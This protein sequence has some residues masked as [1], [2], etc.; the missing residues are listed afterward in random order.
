MPFF[1]PPACS[2]TRQFCSALNVC[3]RRPSFATSA[4]LARRNWI[5]PC[6]A[7]DPSD[8]RNRT[9][10]ASGGVSLFRYTFGGAINRNI[11]SSGPVGR[12]LYDVAAAAATVTPLCAATAA[13]IATATV[14]AAAPAATLTAAAAVIVVAAAV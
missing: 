6:H 3:T 1:L 7:A 14:T 12:D 2:A 13:G 8:L 11:A 5:T 10:S 9:G 4:C